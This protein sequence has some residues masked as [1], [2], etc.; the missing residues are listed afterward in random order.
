MFKIIL[1]NLLG[2]LAIIVIILSLFNLGM[3]LTGKVTD[4][5]SRINITIT[6]TISINFSIDNINFGSG[7]VNI[8]SDSATIDSIGSVVGGN[9]TPVTQGFVL[10][11]IGSNNVSLDLKSGK[12]SA[13]FLGGTNPSYQYNVTNLESGSC[14]EAGITL[15]VWNN[16]NTTGDGD[17]ICS[18]F[19]FIDENDSIRIDLKLVIP[20]DARV[21]SSSDIFTATGTSV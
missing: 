17:K 1:Y 3:Q 5:T 8:G 9:W 15:G 14:T 12:T 6:E 20:H 2:Y 10:E 11:N 19:K 4:S 7:S 21:G 16:V 13:E 18:N